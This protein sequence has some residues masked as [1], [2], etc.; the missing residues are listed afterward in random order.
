MKIGRTAKAT[1][2]GFAIAAL[3]IGVGSN[4]FVYADYAPGPNDIVGVGGDTPQFDASFISD[5]DTSA[6]PGYNTAGNIYKLITF[7]AT[8]DA[9][10]RAGYL[11]GSTLTSPLALNPTDVLRAGT[12]PV[13]R[14]QSSGAAVSALLADTGATET[15][16]F[17][18]SASQPTAAQQT[19]AGNLGWGYL[20]VVQIAT[21][22]VQVAAASTTNAPAGLSPAELV[23]IYN[24]T[25]TKWN[26]LPGNSAGSADTIIPEIPPASSSITKTFLAALKS[27]N[28]NVAVTLAPSVVTVEQNDPSTITSSANSADAIVPFSQARFNLFKSGYF[29]T[30]NTVFP[31]G[32]SV[33]AGIQLLSGTAPDTAAAYSSAVNHYVIFRQSDAVSTTPW[34]P[35]GTKNWVQ[36]LFSNPG[37][38]KPFVASGSGLADIAA[39]GATPA[40]ADL[41]NVS[42]G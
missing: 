11:N 42:N 20:H 18:L 36:T 13:Q 33:P 19:A 3:S 5:G 15:I 8:A 1:L 10:G 40:Y 27:A 37:G 25:Y 22:A 6:D 28:G 38:T 21:D 31:G 4:A 23:G 16:N 2:A 39:S 32:A 30:P 14:V 9:N 7:N 12:V 41:G 35:G 29:H 17:V 34:Q 26:Q 24:G